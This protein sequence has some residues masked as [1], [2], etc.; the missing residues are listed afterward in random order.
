MRYERFGMLLVAALLL[1]GVLDTPLNF[2]RNG[3]LNVLET[4]G[5][6]PLYGLMKLFP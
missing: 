3:L 5:L 6:Q 2:L 1:T 4:I